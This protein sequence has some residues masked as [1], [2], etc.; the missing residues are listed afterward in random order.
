VNKIKG[1][2]LLVAVAITA[3][4]GSG[5][6]GGDSSAHALAGV[7]HGGQSPIV[8]SAVTL[9]AAS[10]QPLSNAT[11]LASSVTD[12]SGNFN[13]SFSCPSPDTEVY[14]TSTGG[15]AGGGST[16]SAIRLMSILGQCQHLP[17]TAVVNELSTL[18]AVYALNPFIASSG[19]SDC[20]GS[21]A[22]VGTINISGPAPGL[23]NA[24]GNALG[25][26]NPANG[27]P[28]PFLPTAA[29]CNVG[30]GAPA[31]CVTLEK[32][33]YLGNALAA[34]VNSTRLTS[35]SCSELLTCAVPGSTLPSSGSPCT[36]PAGSVIPADTLQA[37]LSIARN[38]ATVQASAIAETAA[39]NVVFSPTVSATPT[40]LTLSAYFSGT[41]NMSY[42]DGIA[43]DAAGDAWMADDLYYTT[44]PASFTIE[45]GPN[46]SALSP[47]L[48]YNNNLAA[49]SPAIAIA[50]SN[51]V[52]ATAFQ[53]YNGVAQLSGS[54]GQV[55]SPT[56]GYNY[57]SGSNANLNGIAIDAG[58]YVWVA[59]FINSTIVLLDGSGAV[60]KPGITGGGLSSPDA[61]AVDA[62]GRIWTANSG[63]NSVSE[64]AYRGTALSGAAGYTGGGLSNPNGIAIDPNG[65]VWTAN[66]NNNS[67]TELSNGGVPLSPSTG[68][69]GGGLNEPDHLAVDANGTV[70]VVNAGTGSLSEFSNGGTALSPATVGF[71]GAG[72]ANVKGIAVD[73]SGNLW[74]VDGG[75]GSFPTNPGGVT[76]F[77]GLAA[78]TTTPLI[79]AVTKGFNATNQ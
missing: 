79:N 22:Q 12:A 74:V 4:T 51:T 35:T 24:M 39:R 58:G 67:L 50:A 43:I 77:Y 21:P 5:K 14:V 42:P 48:G 56:N 33:N 47:G 29:A 34:C 16:N 40:D 7:V 15:N 18:A 78:P 60:I 57:S 19:C 38:P 63:N 31:N 11:V 59:D 71:S 65:N 10:A 25:L 41:G 30:S 20:A 2:F 23:P 53:P 66:F 1:L 36:D 46:G 9:Y 27:A 70:W 72:A 28:G 64:F 61:I 49:A 75:S 73:P 44:G 3:C 76:V 6:D 62:N 52:W 69:T 13:F 68:F 32:L 45:L 54:N 37:A 17:E 8:G 55:L 26:V